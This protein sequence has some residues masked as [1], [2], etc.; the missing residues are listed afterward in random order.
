MTR[1][2][3]KERLA[4]HRELA[5]PALFHVPLFLLGQELGHAPCFGDDGRREICKSCEVE[6]YANE[7]DKRIGG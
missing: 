2:Y 4:S 7:N 3:P 6:T 5:S 1:D